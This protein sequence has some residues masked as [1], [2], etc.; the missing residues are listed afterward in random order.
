MKSMTMLLTA[1]AA[2]LAVNSSSALSQQACTQSYVSCMDVCVGRPAKGMQDQCIAA[3]QAKNDQCS[4]KIYGVRKEPV[5][6][7]QQAGE[8]N[9]V[10]AK[11][12]D[13]SAE[14]PAGPAPRQVQAPA[15]SKAAVPTP[16]R[17]Q[18]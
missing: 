9:N 7:T 11:E 17:M 6:T 13:R 2:M 8:A 12:A 3:C 10:L 18:Q 14:P 4:E 16:A 1:T 15:P 5:G